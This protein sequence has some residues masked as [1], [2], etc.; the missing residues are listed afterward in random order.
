[1]RRQDWLG[2][3]RHGVSFFVLEKFARVQKMSNLRAYARMRGETLEE[4]L[5]TRRVPESAGAALCTTSTPA[6]LAARDPSRHLR[7]LRA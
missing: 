3:V 6:S 7:P 2:L 4:F 5:K 1:V